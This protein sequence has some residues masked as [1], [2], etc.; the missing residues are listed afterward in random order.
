MNYHSPTKKKGTKNADER[1]FSPNRAEAQ[2]ES[3]ESRKQANI[4]T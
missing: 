3:F 2:L 1:T 4:D